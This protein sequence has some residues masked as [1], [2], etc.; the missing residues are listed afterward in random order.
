MSSTQP[1]QPSYPADPLPGF[2][3]TAHPQGP[4]VTRVRL[5]GELDIG[6]WATPWP[7][8]PAAA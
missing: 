6:V 3:W 7:K 8:Q 1:S 4:G 2:S 5:S